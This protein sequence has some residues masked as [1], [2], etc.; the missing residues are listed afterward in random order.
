MNHFLSLAAASALLGFCTACAQESDPKTDLERVQASV[1]QAVPELAK[2]NVRPTVTAD[3]YE[4]QL[5]PMYGYVTAD[6]KYLIQG[7]L[8]NIETGEEITENQRRGYRLKRLDELGSA[9]MIEFA[10]AKGARH[11]VTVFTDIDCGYC[12][13][14]HSEIS[15]YNDAGIA[16]RYVFYPR[17][18]MGSDSFRKAE[19][20]W[21]AADRKQAL[22]Q[23]KQGAPVQAAASCSNPIAR[24]WQLGQELGL[25]GTPMMILPDGDVV[26]G[27]VP[28]QQ[29]AMRLDNKPK[30][31]G[32]H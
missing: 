9:N 27:Y 31:D 2:E 24:E 15:E 17:A 32:L 1:T 22:T 16:V 28:P 4:V 11:T 14:L 5:G 26:N 30:M 23:A 29:L 25:R 20:V 12:R 8:V 6:G 18:G 3:L 19:A 10:P 7:D 13:K 21:C